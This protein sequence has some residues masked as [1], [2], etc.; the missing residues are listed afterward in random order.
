MARDEAGGTRHLELMRELVKRGHAATVIAGPTSYLSGVADGSRRKNRVVDGVSVMYAWVLATR[1]RN[2]LVRTLGFLSFTVSSFFAALG[3]RRVDVLWGTSPPIFQAAAA[4]IAARLRGKSF[5]LEV[6]DLWPAFL[7]DAGLLRNPLLIGLARWLE[8]RLCL[9]AECVV[10]N[11]PGFVDHLRSLGVP[12]QRIVLVPNGVDVG[13]FP[14]D[15]NGVPLRREWGIGEDALVAMYT[16]AHGLMN[17]LGVLLNV[18]EQL[19]AVPDVRIVLVGDGREK[20]SL[21]AQASKRALSN[22]VFVPPQPK[23]RM[24]EV[25]AAADV[26]VATLRP[27]PMFRTVYPNKVFD[28]MAAGRPTVLAID[29][30]IREVIERAS[31]GVYVQP[32][33]TQGITRALLGY[34]NDP[35]MGR[36]HGENARA[37]VTEHFDRAKEA[38][39]LEA[40]LRDLASRGRR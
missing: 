4:Y 34:R 27:V 29:G 35:E 8:R 21:I 23:S 16:G 7:I 31:G 17:D 30:V 32:G 37:Y 12:P 24:P 1:S 20:A 33:D 9:G 11:S 26:C 19:R 13:A 38:P 18:A 5:C 40:V 22:V 2:V 28:Y 10:V 3:V 6:R 14:D 36:R 15:V 25:L 39:K